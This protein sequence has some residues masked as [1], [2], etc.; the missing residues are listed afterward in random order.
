M[1]I[2]EIYATSVLIHFIITYALR[3]VLESFILEN[4]WSNGETKKSTIRANRNLFFICMVPI[5][6]L[7]IYYCLFYMAFKKKEL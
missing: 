2:L 1:K 5:F 3:E 4:G 6:R 7:V